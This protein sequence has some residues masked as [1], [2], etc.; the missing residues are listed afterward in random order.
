MR[1]I[2]LSVLGILLIVGAYFAANALIEN[3]K[4]PRSRIN[5][6]TKTVFVDTVVN[7]RIPI[8]VK[9]NGNLTARNRIELFSEVQ[10]IF[11]GG[12]KPFLQAQRYRRGETLIRID[13]AEF[14]AGVQSQ[15]SNLYNL[16]AAAMP[17]IRLDYPEVFEKWQAYLDRFDMKKSTPV[18]PEIVSDRER[19]FINGRG[20]VQAYYDVK[21]SEQRL[22]KYVITAPFDGVLVEALVNEGTLV[23]NGQKLGE[24]IDPSVYEMPVSVNRSF[25]HLLKTGKEVLLT[26][27]EGA[28]QWKGKVVRVNQSVDQQTQTVTA[29]VEVRGENLREGMYLEAALQAREEEKAIE[30][31]RNLLTEAKQVFIVKDSILDVIDVNPVFFSDRTVVI[32]NAPDGTVLLARPVPGAYPG[33]LV[34]VYREEET[35]KP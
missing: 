3:K 31:D 27:L 1:K 15:K 6:I 18:L 35:V 22:V 16:I 23:R 32:T 2:I 29:F 12:A 11:E 21:N 24:F 9:A 28:A 19:Y 10:G 4:K 34:K 13:A 8:I 20:I 17:D 14:Y 26:D 30:I 7:G 33:M 25:A 5:R